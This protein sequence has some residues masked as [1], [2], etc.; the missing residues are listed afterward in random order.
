MAENQKLNLKIS[1]LYTNPNQF[2]EL[3]E[4]ALSKADNCVIDKGSVIESRRGFKQYGSAL[5]VGSG[6]VDN[7][8]TYKSRLLVAYNSKIAYDSDGAG[9]WVD[10]SGTYIPPTGYKIQSIQQNGNLYFT[11]DS[12]IKKLQSLTGTIGNAG[13][14][15][16]LDGIGSTTGASGF[17][18]NGNNVAYRLVWGIKDANNNLI[19]GSPSGRL[20]VANS[21]GGTRNISL[22][23]TIPEG[24]TT[25]HYFAVYRSPQ[26]TTSIEPNDELQQVYEDNP[27]SAQ[28]TAKSLTFTDITS[29]ELRGAFLY[30]SSSQEGI[31]QAN[32]IPPVSKDICLYKQMVFF[33]NSSTFQRLTITLIAVGSGAF[34]T[35]DTITLGGVV[36]TGAVAENSAIG[37]FQI[38]TA[39]TVSENIENT[40]FSLVRVI[41]TYA[42]NTTI[43][44][45]YTSGYNDLPGRIT[46][47]SRTVGASAFVAISSNGDNFNPTL[48]TSGSTIIS[49]NDSAQNR[50][51][52]SKVGQ[53]EAVPLLNYVNA[54]SSDF[55]VERIIPLRDSIFILKKDGI[56]R[57]I[58]EDPSSLRLSVFDNTATIASRN[59]AVEIS[60]TIYFYSDQGIGQISD[61][62]FQV[63][64]RPIEDLLFKIENFNSFDTTSFS[65]AYESDRKYIF[66]CKTVSGDSQ[67][68]QAFVYNQFTNAWTR[69]ERN[70][71]AGTVL[72]SQIYL[73][74]LTGQVYQE[75]KDFSLTDYQDEEYAI[76]ITSSSGLVV[77]YTGTVTPTIGMLLKQGSLEAT[78]TAIGSGSITV[79]TIVAWANSS[80]T[81]FAP[82]VCEMEWAQESAGN[83]GVLKHFREVTLIMRDSSFNSIDIGFSTNLDLIPEYVTIDSELAGGWGTFPWGSLAWGGGSGVKPIP[84]RTYIPLEKARGSWIY[85]RVRSTKAKANFAISGVSL[86]YS[87]M[88]S[89][90]V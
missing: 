73:A 36:Y 25:S 35:G 56:F 24:I 50:I 12:G 55:P 20:V 6:Q 37:N 34:N 13:T 75:R 23:W 32:E 61:N 84:I 58:G 82:I 72:D 79:D 66:F 64:S 8:M 76:T 88:S 29:D 1:G 74:D 67:A 78:V 86:I 7:F 19:V 5:T 80:A 27:S 53:P 63:M 68:T 44:A 17:L 62:G 16:A 69:W 57:I 4:G 42:S 52:Y 87:G 65:V 85:L 21:S 41:N 2:S 43:Y 11:T 89:R 3:P 10:Y 33:A 14:P 47:E 54:G 59:A 18:S 83:P 77:N 26:V 60:N 15:K 28:I 39:G 22:T 38:F 48:P 49:T 70:A 51:Y 81:L 31:L 40:A 9:A 71:T 90:F 30:T 45:Y 46:L